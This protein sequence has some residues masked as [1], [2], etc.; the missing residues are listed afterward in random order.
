MHPMFRATVEQVRSDG[1]IYH[2]EGHG[3]A[4]Q[5]DAIPTQGTL[6]A[7]GGS[8]PTVQ[9]SLIALKGSAHRLYSRP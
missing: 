1:A 2:V 8:L 9:R 7:S 6:R 5:L 3:T 4:Q